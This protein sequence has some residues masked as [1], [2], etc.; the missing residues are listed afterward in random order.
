MAP[1]KSTT[2]K[3]TSRSV[4]PFRIC[5]AGSLQFPSSTVKQTK[6]FNYNFGGFFPFITRKT[7]WGTQQ[8]FIWGGS[9]TRSNLLIFS[10]HFSRKRYPFRIL[11]IDKCYPFP[12]PCLV[13]WSP[14]TVN[15]LLS[16][17]EYESQKQNAFL[18]L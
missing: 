10:F 8:I 13:L 6:L 12:I 7:P 1:I 3:L 4:L 17:Y 16:K 5:F 9:A 14:F 11:S 15:A 18:T 2:N